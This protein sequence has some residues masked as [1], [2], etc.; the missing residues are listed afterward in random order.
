MAEKIIQATLEGNILK[1]QIPEKY[2]DETWGH[3][4]PE[5]NIET[6]LGII[7]FIRRY[8]NGSDDYHVTYIYK[9][10][11]DYY[12]NVDSNYNTMFDD[13]SNMILKKCEVEQVLIVKE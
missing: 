12:F 3:K 8:D 5:E 7:K 11:D 9:L 6:N 10:H 4:P 1:T 2:L 13:E